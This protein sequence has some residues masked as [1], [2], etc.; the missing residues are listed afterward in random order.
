M[1]VYEDED[2]HLDLDI[3]MIKKFSK[4]SVTVPT[5]KQDLEKIIKD[6]KELKLAFFIKGDEEREKAKQ[7]FLRDQK[8][9]YQR[10]EY[11]DEEDDGA[12]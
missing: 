4:L 3:S 9:K 2:E 6:L 5:K 10:D 7:K 11:Y 1:W 12:E 8:R